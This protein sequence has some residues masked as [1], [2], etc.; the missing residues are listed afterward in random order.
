MTRTRTFFPCCIN[1]WNKLK[2]GVWNA[3]SINIFKKS[4]VSEKKEKWLFFIYDPLGVKFLTRLRLRHLNE[5][6]FRRGF[7]DAVNLLVYAKLKF[8]LLNISSC[9]VNFKVLKDENILK[10]LR[11]LNQIL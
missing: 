5:H 7:S 3:E 4:I 1:E 10:I 6:K 8:K 2:V 9:V 11:K